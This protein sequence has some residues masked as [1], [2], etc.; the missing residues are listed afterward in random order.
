M[1]VQ[2]HDREMLKRVK[3][4]VYRKQEE[5]WKLVID[6]KEFEDLGKWG[7]SFHTLNE[8]QNEIRQELK[9]KEQ[10]LE[11]T[12]SNVIENIVS[13]LFEVELDS[14]KIKYFEFLKSHNPHKYQQIVD[15]VKRQQLMQQQYPKFANINSHSVTP[16]QGQ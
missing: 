3:E 2:E 15:E 7:E 10:I 12:I 13:P 1:N 16:R 6:K 14:L 9:K 11:K 8:T 4:D 5:F